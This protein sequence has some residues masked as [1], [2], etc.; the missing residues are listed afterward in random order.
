[1]APGM[2]VDHL[3]QEL[4]RVER[5]RDHLRTRIACLEERNAD[6]AQYE[7]GIK[8][9]TAVDGS[10]DMSLSMGHDMMRLLVA[11][12]AKVADEEGGPN[13]AELRFSLAGTTEMWT[14]TIQRPN[15]KTSGEVADE[16]RARA[17][18]AEAEAAMMRLQLAAILNHAVGPAQPTDPEHEAAHAT[19]QAGSSTSA[20][21]ANGNEATCK[22]C[23]E[24]I[25]FKPFF[26]DGREP[27][28][29]VWFHPNA[30]STCSTRP[31]SWDSGTWPRAEPADSC[32]TNDHGGAAYSR[33]EPT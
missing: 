1:M 13:F 5:E 22:H 8:N 2:D 18:A 20:D 30:G 21:R 32:A 4:D 17:E 29:P 12:V 28:P 15:G 14:L 19:F 31:E 27:N 7:L 25:V 16:Q 3:V 6:L 33:E 9:L 24:R 23:G 10:I 11:G 26:L